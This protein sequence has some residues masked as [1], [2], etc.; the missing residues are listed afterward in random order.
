MMLVGGNA[1]GGFLEQ[2]RQAS[3]FEAQGIY[4]D[5]MY[6]H[7]AHIADLQFEDALQRGRMAAN[8]ARSQG[9]TLIGAQRAAAAEAG[10]DVADGTAVEL[11]EESELFSELDAVR[12]SNDATR[13]AWG[14]QVQARDYRRQGVLSRTAGQNAARGARAASYSTLLTGGGQIFDIYDRNR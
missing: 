2:R 4:E 6:E 10:I 7:N 12:L 8:R 3:A 13:E 9:R 11:I 1:V 14:F 5:R